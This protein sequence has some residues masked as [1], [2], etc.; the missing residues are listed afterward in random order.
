[1]P[2][3][4]P[5]RRPVARPL[6]LPSLGPCQRVLLSTGLHVRWPSYPRPVHPFL[7]PATRCS[8]RSPRL[9]VPSAIPHLAHPRTRS[10]VPPSLFSSIFSIPLRLSCI[11]ILVHLHS[12]SVF[13]PILPLSPSGRLPLAV[14][15]S[16]GLLPGSLLGTV[17]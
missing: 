4:F 10:L 3:W 17:F 8:S 12:V 14:P 6:V 16:L 5:S 9:P 13:C 15:P 1:M 2:S 7:A 11:R